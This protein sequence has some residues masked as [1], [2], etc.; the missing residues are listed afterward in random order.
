MRIALIVEGCYPYVTGGV[1]TWCDQLVRG[2]SDYEFEVV[3]ITATSRVTPVLELPPNVTA[4]TTVP[5]W[6]LTPS[7]R[8]LASADRR[9]FLPIYRRIVAT[10]LDA[11]L[12]QQEFDSALAELFSFAQTRGLV[13]VMRDDAVVQVL[14]DTWAALH[15]AVPIH[16]REAVQATEL[17]EHM[18]LPLAAPPPEVDV[19]H[20]VSNGLPAL[21]ALAAKWRDGTPIVMSEHGVYLRERYL[22]LQ[23]ASYRW[24][25]KTVMLAFM[26]RICRSA[27]EAADVI[28]PVNVYNRRWEERH[29]AD[30]DR[31]HTVY[32]GVDPE[33]LPPAPGD[34][35]VPTVGWIGRVDPLKDLHTLVRAFAVVNATM[36]EAVLRLFGPTPA[37]NEAYERSVRELVTALGLDDVVT[38]EGPVRP[39]TKA[40]HASTVVALSSISEGLPYTAME[41]MMCRRATV[42]TDVGGVL[43]V[44]GDTGLVVGARDPIALGTALLEQLTNEA[45]RQQM[46]D[47]ARTRA[48]ELFQLP[49]M[50]ASFR[51]LYGTVW[52]NAATTHEPVPRP[53]HQT[54]GPAPVLSAV[55]QLPGVLS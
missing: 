52:A 38:F 27:Y 4:V 36:P 46:A 32:N 28:T 29:G 23:S 20:A 12:P 31:I 10:M 17:M 2:L 1:S 47:R 45:L 25:V 7:P 16:V 8:R 13:S 41:A 19:T 6:D 42:S 30:P 5:L 55:R 15:P 9:G 21:I 54:V 49:T 14:T 35:A 18:L 33:T 44:V 50:L 40:Y 26:R 43:E 39:A 22:S 3:A 24:P 37:G 34:P 51:E 53:G 11:S 48:L